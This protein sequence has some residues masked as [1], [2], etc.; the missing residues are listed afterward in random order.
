MRDTV[1]FLGPTLAR[2]HAEPLLDAEYLPPIC[3]GDLAKLPEHIRFVGII[4]GEFSRASLS[5][6]KRSSLCCAAE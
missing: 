5:H 6:P 2:E 4:D 1:V 3:R